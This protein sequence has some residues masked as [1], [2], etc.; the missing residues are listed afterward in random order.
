MS[1]LDADL[2]EGRGWTKVGDGYAVTKKPRGLDRTKFATVPFAAMEA[3][4]QGG[5]YSPDFVMKPGDA[6]ASGTYFERGDVLVGKITPSFENGKQALI[7]ELPAPFGYA[8]T[9][10]IPLHPISDR[11][12]PRFL[13]FYLLHPDVRH[14]VAERM[15]GSTGRKRVPEHV[16]LDLAIPDLSQVE[17]KAVADGLE[18]LHRAITAEGY[19]ERTAQDLKR[20][21]MRALF[22]KGL[23]GE[24]QKETEIGLV[25]E[26]WELRSL[27][28]LCDIRSGGTPRKSVPEYWN[29]EIPWVSGKDLK[30]P[31]LDDAIDH[32]S[33]EGVEAGSRLAPAG[34]VLV[35][36]RGMGL[37]KDLPVAVITRPMAFNQDIKALV[38]RGKFSGKFLRSAIYVHKDRLLARIVPSAHGTMTLNLNDIETFMVPCPADPT[39]ADEIVAILDAIDRKIDLHRRKRAVLDELFKALLHKLMTG[40]IRVADLDLSAPDAKP[41]AEVAA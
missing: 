3:I 16:L 32:V 39:E 4:P 26:S 13:F 2:G 8:T 5:A 1:L 7:Q 9:E 17:Q 6:I 23:R 18:T 33:A 12:D 31:T 40:E 29:G 21:A 35:L 25:P 11:H 15:E 14:Y 34:T 22:T 24:A 38:S 27:L 20:A 28:D 36:V 30:A 37:A 19:C 10:V 41:V